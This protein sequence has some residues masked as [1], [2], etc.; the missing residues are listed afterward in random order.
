MAG[1]SHGRMCDRRDTAG[2]STVRW[3]L[4]RPIRKGSRATHGC[5]YSRVFLYTFKPRGRLMELAW[6]SRV[7]VAVGEVALVS[8]GTA[9]QFRPSV[10]SQVYLHSR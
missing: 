2:S 4:P 10:Q 7:I 6:Q 8:N 3:C 1:G 9:G 5:A